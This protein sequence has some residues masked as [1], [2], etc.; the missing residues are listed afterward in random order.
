MFPGR[1]SHVSTPLRGHLYSRPPSLV[2]GKTTTMPQTN[3]GRSCC[4]HK[5]LLVACR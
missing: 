4:W 1:E 3:N 2:E 5:Q